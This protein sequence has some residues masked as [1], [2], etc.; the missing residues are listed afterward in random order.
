MGRVFILR[1]P[2][3]A[4]AVVNPDVVQRIWE[5]LTGST[6]SVDLIVK[7]SLPIGPCWTIEAQNACV[8]GYHRVLGPVLVGG[9][10]EELEL[11]RVNL[12]VLR[13]GRVSRV[14]C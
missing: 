10:V 7:T 5:A 4:H 1:C 3:R 2:V 9:V 8:L 12:A 13:Y 14:V 11:T 6:S